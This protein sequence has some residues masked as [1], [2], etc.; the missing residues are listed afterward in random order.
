MGE[1][2]KVKSLFYDVCAAGNMT[3]YDLL[4][5]L[6]CARLIHF[7]ASITGSFHVA[8]EIVSD[9]FI[10]LWQ[11]R[12]QLSGVREPLVYLVWRRYPVQI[13]R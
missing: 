5:R 9:V 4:Y 7:S 1:S 13:E 6:L 2:E 12:D 8:E 11:K 10:M 3:S